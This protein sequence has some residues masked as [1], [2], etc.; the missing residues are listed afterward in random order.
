MSDKKG[1]KYKKNNSCK[2]IKILKIADTIHL[3]KFYTFWN[4]S[5]HFKTILV[6]VNSLEM[7]KN[8]NGKY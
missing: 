8:Y 5:M 3:K 4:I 2:V 7:I 6:V 1:H